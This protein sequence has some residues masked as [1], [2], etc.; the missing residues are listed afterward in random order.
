MRSTVSALILLAFAMPALAAPVLWDVASGGNGHYY[1]AFWGYGDTSDWRYANALAEGR[2][3]DGLSGHLATI[4]S[5]EE[6]DWVVANLNLEDF[7][8][9]TL[10]EDGGTY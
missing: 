7:P 2:M 10:D 1:E 4:T 5:Q 6:F 8:A 9:S 3:Y